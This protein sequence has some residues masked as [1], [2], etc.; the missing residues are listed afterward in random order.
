[1]IVQ[2]SSETPVQPFFKTSHQLSPA[3]S[4]PEP[5]Q[6]VSKAGWGVRKTTQ[7]MSSPGRIRTPNHLHHLPIT[8]GVK[9]S[10]DFESIPVD[11][12]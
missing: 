3:L 4:V 7:V 10:G 9:R 6:H 1:M 11:I 12:D 5:P 2:F 8:I